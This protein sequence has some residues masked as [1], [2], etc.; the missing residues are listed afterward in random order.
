MSAS[1]FQACLAAASNAAGRQLTDAEQD[2]IFTRAH[3]RT[4]FYQLQGMDPLSAAQRAGG[5]LGNELRQA[6]AI[7]RRQHARNQI[8]RR[9]LDARVRPGQEY[10]SVLAVL[11]GVAR[12]TDRDLANSVDAT[13]HGLSNTFRGAMVANLRRAG[14]LDVLR[15]R[16]EAFERDLAREL[17]R[18]RDPALPA[19]GNAP[20]QQAAEILGQVQDALRNQLN[21]A[22]A[23]ISE[24][25][26]YI[27]R[28]S[29]D[30]L[31]VRGDGT[32]QAYQ[33]WRDFILPRLDPITFRDAA[34][35]EQFLRNVWN[36]LASG[37][38]TTSTS[39][40]LA[41]FSG[42][43]SV[44][45]KVSQERVLHFASADAWFDYN[46]AFGRGNVFDAVL[47]QVE[48]GSRDVALMR[49][50]GTNPGAM[51]Q[52]WID[53]LATQLRDDGRA[54]DAGRLA[55]SKFP[56]QVLAILDGRAATP[57]NPTLAQIGAGVRG[58]QQLA[59]LGGVMLSALPDLSVNAAALRHNGVPLFHAYSQEMLGLLPR[60]RAT[61][62]IA[63]SLGVGI[64]GLL[65][66][67]AHRLGPDDGMTGRVAR[68][69]DLFHRLNGLTW[70][71][72]RMKESAGLM[73]SSNLAEHAGQDFASLPGR[74]QA[75]LRR[76]GIEDAEWT[77]LRATPQ[78]AADGRSYILPDAIGDPEL[79]RKVQAYLADQVREGMT[80]GSASSRAIATLGTQSGSW[81]G[82]LVR[83]LMQFKSYAVTYMTRS[84]GRELTRDGVDVQGVAHLL[85]ATTALGYLAMT[86][87]ELAKGRAPRQPDDPAT[88]VKLVAAAMV[89]GGGMGI[90]GD[91]L[92]GENNRFGGGFVASLAGPTAGTLEEAARFLANRLRGEGHA[93]AEAIRMGA[94][95]TPLINL[96]YTRLG[97]D[98]AVLWRLQEWANPGYLRRMEQRVKRENDQTFWLRPTEAVR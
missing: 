58:L 7:E 70:W 79:Q 19:S 10:D 65:G 5:E 26:H 39:E 62:E 46:Q 97:I 85:V 83:T 27:T 45:K 96:F 60:G 44:A 32:P 67:I 90:Y 35:P 81:G 4:R 12:G 15:T 40:T 22:G 28:Q 71:T 87:K 56:D 13:W 14:L 84:M 2:R 43:G 49:H 69:A 82:E 64:D 73:L 93:A 57:E 21:D 77:A 29:H 95:H 11:S 91:F 8:I 86:M 48:K 94:N 1:N 37:V 50:L 24:L 36:N 25:D 30:Q 98:Y 66:H 38:H 92:F 52:G 75:T 55:S 33:A 89:Q 68:A 9:Q 41:G 53:R 80:E 63:D 47:A 51:L 3:H 6:A 54:A 74:M 20:A 16:D 23:W 34:D 42:P 78:R 61:R 31:R 17:W 59:R 76:Y 18:R 72:D 88:A